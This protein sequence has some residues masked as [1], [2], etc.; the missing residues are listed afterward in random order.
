MII[1]HLIQYIQNHQNLN[2]LRTP[3][4]S[5]ILRTKLEDKFKDLTI[6]DIIEL[7][8]NNFTNKQL[9]ELLDNI[10]DDDNLE[11]RRYQRI[12]TYFY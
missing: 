4:N 7:L 2:L 12:K 8:F 5:Q 1:I 6:D 10:E 9:H 3:M 11:E